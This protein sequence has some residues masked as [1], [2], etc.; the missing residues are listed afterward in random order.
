VLFD[1]DPFD[2]AGQRIKNR[3]LNWEDVDGTGLERVV[4]FMKRATTPIEG[5][6]FEDAR[7]A[8]SFPHGGK[9]RWRSYGTCRWHADV[10]RQHGTAAGR[11]ALR[12]SGLPPR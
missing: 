10:L 5:E 9:H 7:A 11:T 8:L 4:E 3:G 6:R 1:K 12:L 2:F